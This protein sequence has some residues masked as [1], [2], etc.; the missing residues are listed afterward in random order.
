MTETIIT[1]YDYDQSVKD[2]WFIRWTGLLM[3]FLGIFLYAIDT[4]ITQM[5]MFIWVCVTIFLLFF[6]FEYKK[7]TK[8]FRRIEY[9]EE[10]E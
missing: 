5:S 8:R 2:L 4:L 1:R 9:E 3:M 6:P 10:I 7:Y